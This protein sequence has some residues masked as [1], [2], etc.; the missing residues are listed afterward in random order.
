MGHVGLSV[1]LFKNEETV[2]VAFVQLGDS[3][4]LLILKLFVGPARTSDI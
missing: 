1:A 2:F 3:I 4:V